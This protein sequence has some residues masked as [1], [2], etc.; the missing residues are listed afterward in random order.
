MQLLNAMT[1]SHPEAPTFT[2]L[3]PRAKTALY[4]KED[5]ISYTALLAHSEALAA[6]F[7]MPAGAR[8]VLFAE[9]RPEWLAALHAIWRCGGVV[10]PVDSVAQADELAYIIGQTEPVMIVC[11]DKTR[12][13]IDQA[14]AG[15][16]A[17]I[18]S[19]DDQDFP[20]LDPG[21]QTATRLESGLLDNL[22][23]I[24]YTS[25]TTGAPKGVMLTFRNLLANLQLVC[26]R[27]PVF[28]ADSRVF[29][30]LPAHHILPLMGC[31]LAP[32]YAGG[33]I[34]LAHSLDP[35][36]MVATLRRHRCTM[37]IG[38][39]RLYA[40][41]RKAVMDKLRAS[42]VGRALFSLSAMVNRQPFSR[43][44]LF[45]VQR[46]FGG[47]LRQLVSGGAPLD[48]EVAEDL[49]V[50]GFEV[51]EGYGMTE[52]A[53]MIS[54]PTPG[55]VRLGSCGN[56]NWPDS[57]R[58]EEDEI[59][60][61]GPN[62]FAGYWRNP[63]ATAEVLSDGWLHTG[64][65]GYLDR[66]GYLFING[67]R[68]EMIVLSSGKKVNPVELE[69]KLAG[70][71]ADAR[72]LAV[73]LHDQ[74][75]HAL[76]QPVPGLCDDDPEAQAEHFRWPLLEPYNRLV[77]S[78]KKITQLSIVTADLPK[79]RLGKL[80]RHELEVLVREGGAESA[81]PVAVPEDLASVYPVFE[82]FLQSDLECPR[83]R[84]DSHWEMDLGLDSLAQLSVLIF[85][86]KVFGIRL[87]ESIFQECPTVIGLVRHAYER[88]A[89]FHEQAG[90]WGSM[91]E[92]GE[93]EPLDLPRST[94]VHLFL[95]ASLGF[96]ARL[97]FRIEAKGLENI[98]KEGPCILAVNHQSYFDGLFVSMFLN[99]A[100]LRRTYY[101]AKQKH[102]KAGVLAWMAR[103]S[104]VIVVEVG[105]DVGLSLRKL[106]QALRHQGNL[107]IFPEGTRSA[108]GKLGEF[109][110]AFAKLAL[111]LKIPVVPVAISGAW[112]AM[113]ANGLPR[114]LTRIMVEFLPAVRDSGRASEHLLADTVR[115]NIA[116]HTA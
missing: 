86:E 47:A 42:P 2:L 65:L 20:S 78:A 115:D 104:N 58:V 34:V 13:V 74:R 112:R 77:S 66:E 111:E 6:A 103:N 4:W 80:K 38:V 56:P 26:E 97:L 87:P 36:E 55:R 50:L 37:M 108:D 82:Q 41:I 71:C 8:A 54:F 73:V 93:E 106:G 102:V 5:R 62:V 23:A 32:L 28:R 21:V 48:R 60:T 45:A 89:F 24:L 3:E 10:V 84:P 110:T 107:L 46:K 49:T 72:D 81:K 12:P 70:M 79:T 109:K 16:Q 92:G 44:L 98:P 53:P 85:V 61:R 18:V 39:P 9:N 63:E 14:L 116:Q 113:R 96:I 100:F 33:S 57:V 22:A 95:K 43:I 114:P 91:L 88:R 15:A 17:H 19:F 51:L 27:V 75:L 101:Y 68:K 35:A 67:R 99:N 31:M 25:G 40:L 94:W 29:S 83:V 11:S 52:C 105:R 69:E 76:I 7:P 90:D 1:K 59:L 64:D 30:L